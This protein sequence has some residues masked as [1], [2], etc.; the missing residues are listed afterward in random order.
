MWAVMDE[1]ALRRQVGTPG[2]MYAQLM[3]MVELGQRENVGIQVIPAARAANAGN[4]GP[5][6]VAS[7]DDGEVMLME[8][9]EDVTTDKRSTVRSG[10]D[11]F[12]R[13]RW[14][15]LSGPESLELIAKVAE[16][17]TP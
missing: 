1:A 16:E 2:V 12:D 10:M 9:V 6:T 13:V 14:V 15:A 5:F 17:W 11:T 8:A 3:H 7:L 4:V